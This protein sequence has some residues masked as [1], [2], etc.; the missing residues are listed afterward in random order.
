MN[1]RPLTLPK[2]LM[3]VLLLFFFKGEGLAQWHNS[4]S[5]CSS[6]C[7]GT[8]TEYYLDIDLDGFG[9]DD[10]TWNI[11]H[12]ADEA[13]GVIPEGYSATAGDIYPTDGLRHSNE[14]ST[15]IEGCT[16]P[17]AC[18]YDTLATVEDGTCLFPL[19]CQECNPVTKTIAVDSGTGKVPCSCDEDD[20]SVAVFTDALGHC[21][22]DCAVDNDGDAICDQF[23][24]STIVSKDPCL[25]N[26]VN[27]LDHCGNCQTDSTNG[28][29]ARNVQTQAL[30]SL[31][32][33][34]T[35]LGGDSTG[36]CNCQQTMKLN[37]CLECVLIADLS[38]PCGDLR[39]T[40]DTIP[41][42]VYYLS[43]LSVADS[44]GNGILDSEDIEGCIDSTACN[45]NDKATWGLA[46]DW[47]ATEDIC[48]VC[49]GDAAYVDSSN[50]ALG[51]VDGRC[52]CLTYPEFAKKCDGTCINDTLPNDAYWTSIGLTDSLGTGTGNGICDELEVY[53]CNVPQACNYDETATIFQSGVCTFKDSLDVCGGNCFADVDDDGICDNVDDCVGQLDVCGVCEGTGIP[54]GYCNCHGDTLDALQVCGGKCLEDLDNDL[55][56]DYFIQNGDT[57]LNDHD[58]C[59]GTLDAIGVCDGSC[60]ED[61]DDDG[62]CDTEDTCLTGTGVIDDC[63]DC[64]GSQFFTLPDGS[65][66]IPGTAANCLNRTNPLVTPTCNCLGDTL[67]A[68]NVCGGAC[69]TDADNDGICDDGGGDDCSGTVD[70]CGVCDGGGIPAG[71]CNCFG[72]TLDALSV[73][74]GTCLVDA[75]SDGICDLDIYNNVLDNCIN[76]TLDSCGVCGGSGPLPGCGCEPILR[77]ECDCDGN[78]ADLCGVCG[79]SGPDFGRDC[80]GNCLEDV[81]EDGICDAFDPLVYSVSS[82]LEVEVESSRL[83]VSISSFN[84][85]QAFDMLIARHKAMST[86]LDDGSLTGTSNHITIQDSVQNNGELLVEGDSY[87][88]SKVQIDGPLHVKGNVSVGGDFQVAGTT[89]NNGGLNSANVQN[90]GDIKVGGTTNVG[91]NMNIS[92]NTVVQNLGHVVG[93]I[94]VHNGLSSGTFDNTG[95][96]VNFTVSGSSG[97]V[98]M[99]G[100]ATIQS[101]LEVGQI[102]VLEQELEVSRQ[103]RARIAKMSGS[104]IANS[105]LDVGGNF[106]VNDSMFTVFGQT[107]LTRINGNLYVD[108]NVVIRGS[109]LL[110]SSLRVTGTTFADGGMF[111]TNVNMTGN[112]VVDNDINVYTNTRVAGQT[113]L[114]R[115]MQ[116]GSN[117]YLYNNET[118]A[119]KLKFSV[120]P[121]T[122]VRSEGEVQGQQAHIGT[123]N[124]GTKTTVN[125]GGISVDGNVT[126]KNGTVTGAALFTSADSLLLSGTTTTLKDS[127][128]ILDRLVADGPASFGKI[129]SSSFLDVN[130]LTISGGTSS[131]V[132]GS[133]FNNTDAR[134]GALRVESN[135][136]SSEGVISIHNA[137]S[138][139]HGVKIQLDAAAPNNE[140]EY[141]RFVT[142]G[143]V[144]IGRIEGETTG[145]LV[146]NLGWVADKT[147]FDS[148]LYA[149]DATETFAHAS[150]IAAEVNR[151]NAI[152]KQVA[153]VL[154]ITACAGWGFC[155]TLP[156]P[157]MIVAA[158]TNLVLTSFTTAE[159]KRDWDNA[160]SALR[161]SRETTTIF[162]TN[163]YGTVTKVAAGGQMV[164]VA[165]ASGSGDYAEYLPKLNPLQEMEAGQIVGIQQGKISFNTADADNLFVISTQPIVLGN[166]PEENKDH[167]EKAAFLGQVPVWVQG[168]VQAGDFILPSGNFDGFGIAI[169]QEKASAA[170]LANLVGIAWESQEE[171]DLVLVNVAVGISNGVAQVSKQ[172]DHRLTQLEEDIVE[173]ELALN[174]KMRGKKMTLYEAQR[175]G[176]IPP[177]IRPESEITYVKNDEL[178]DIDKFKY[179]TSDDVILHEIT[180][181]AMEYAFDLAVK[182]WGRI[183]NGKSNLLRDIERDP[184]LKKAMLKQI[185]DDINAYNDKFVADLD[186][187]NS[188]DI[189]KPM[190]SQL[191]EKNPLD[192]KG[193]NGHKQ[194]KKDTNSNS[195]RD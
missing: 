195:K 79:G 133:N 132:T 62:I 116:V 145:E 98:R 136:T 84:V 43:V 3:S 68:I 17:S 100:D 149:S 150:Y 139:G 50:T 38:L 115:G 70:E 142:S 164:G 13:L 10:S 7:S 66:C 191:T 169:H 11:Y 126:V 56:C 112:M 161:R 73:C 173:M 138:S 170:D 85:D 148:D 182:D 71:D 192:Y 188:M 69:L 172:L 14:A 37:E 141:V 39:N 6:A 42:S 162:N 154:S 134:L 140:N 59:L 55:V 95:S 160:K 152:A 184:A 179:I 51:L 97:K 60:T 29:W 163:S 26:S 168:P 180:D 113:R 45:Y 167:Y 58:I 103:A 52:D 19:S 107:G 49:G 90:S 75:D 158:A 144:V 187:Y 111:T 122:R 32:K 83:A 27:I 105:S 34:A 110:K 137:N 54:A 78:V 48:N 186:R 44:V 93:D 155:V 190:T 88:D 8:C 156:I 86:N 125:S 129:S 31:G 174:A 77:G 15:L 28:S 185:K 87:F 89:F 2:L 143:D 64:G 101:E 118:A 151:A 4:S 120:K 96:R 74:G 53:G 25:N 130:G 128:V 67:D 33:D 157:S 171:E 146:N 24:D 123:M 147:S 30:S 127:L 166:E 114:L 65:P 57:V 102:G 177:L 36:Y 124:V 23:A 41:N 47:C 121:G 82:P 106:R 20:P 40:I 193:S 165:F 61:S 22:G 119:K 9:V 175:A 181:E 18:N 189:L 94:N 80:D 1:F 91:G 72:D 92:G 21:G 109:S 117:L 81:D 183:T 135:S 178:P 159:A 153:A 76:Q 108:G 99:D 104:L 63:E 176:L 35:T 131:G 12:C 46:A 5:S 16:F 194:S